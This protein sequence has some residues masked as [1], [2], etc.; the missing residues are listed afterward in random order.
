MP[1]LFPSTK[2]RW[3]RAT[4]S[5]DPQCRRKPGTAFCRTRSPRCRMTLP[6]PRAGLFLLTC[7]NG[8]ARGCLHSAAISCFFFSARVSGWTGIPARVVGQSSWPAQ[9]NAAIKTH[10]AAQ[11]L[12]RRRSRPGFSS[13]FLLAN[14]FSPLNIFYCIHKMSESCASASGHAQTLEVRYIFVHIDLKFTFGI[15]ILAC[16]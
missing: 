1:S 9:R 11:Y 3:R 10:R 4:T 14:K 7:T 12:H 5:P 15:P 16:K 8:P 2:K 13:A 6:Y